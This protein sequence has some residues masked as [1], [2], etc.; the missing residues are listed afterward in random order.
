MLPAAPAHSK[1]DPLSCAPVP[2]QGLREQPKAKG[3]RKEHRGAAGQRSHRGRALA[4]LGTCSPTALAA[5]P[6]EQLLRLGG[7]PREMAGEDGCCWAAAGGIPE[8]RCFPPHP[9]PPL[10]WEVWKAEAPVCPADPAGPGSAAAQMGEEGKATPSEPSQ[11][12]AEPRR[13]P[14]CSQ[15]FPAL[16]PLHPLALTDC[17]PPSSGPP[18]VRKELGASH[19]QKW[20]DLEL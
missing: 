3:R 16:P 17:L 10:E 9:I 12:R 6:Q 5:G 4:L 11:P 8:A 1:R 13:D 15:V 18:N 19:R 20:Q 2:V 7:H 14:K